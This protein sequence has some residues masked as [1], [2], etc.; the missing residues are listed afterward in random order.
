V[1]TPLAAQRGHVKPVAP[2]G[3]QGFGPNPDVQDVHKLFRNPNRS[4]EDFMRD[5]RALSADVRVLEQQARAVYEKRGYYD[6]FSPL[7]R[8]ARG[9]ADLYEEWAAR[10]ERAF[11]TT[12]DLDEARVLVRMALDARFHARFEVHRGLELNLNQLDGALAV[13]TASAH[14]LANV[15][16]GPDLQRLTQRADLAASL[17]RAARLDLQALSEPIADPEDSE[18]VE[19]LTQAL[20]SNDQ[21]LANEWAAS[22]ERTRRI[23]LR[24]GRDLFTVRLRDKLKVELDERQMLRERA[25]KIAEE[26]VVLAPFTREGDNPPPE[27]EALKKVERYRRC[28]GLAEQA[29]AWDPLLPD[30]HYFLAEAY[31][32]L[33]GQLI[34][35]PYF[36]RYLVLRGIRFYDQGTIKNRNLTVREQRALDLLTAGDLQATPPPLPVPPR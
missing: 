23:A 12:Y 4:D 7:E 5:L 25:A 26:L 24:M 31:A 8:P 19:R 17:L 18:S 21:K 14:G 32:Y 33:A 36:D 3:R 35:Q 20:A 28:A 29:L 2:D 15:Q 1:L 30:L 27:I 13:L 16:P 9:I 22:I 10:T 34:A 11:D 6:L